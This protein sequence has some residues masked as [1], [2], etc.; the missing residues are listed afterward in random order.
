[1]PGQAANSALASTLPLMRGWGL[2]SSSCPDSRSHNLLGLIS[3]DLGT[4]VAVIRGCATWG[5]AAKEGAVSDFNQGPA[6]SSLERF[7]I[8]ETS[9]PVAY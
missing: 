2:L 8:C 6:C 4:I 9:T 7:S 3:G 1:M 5:I